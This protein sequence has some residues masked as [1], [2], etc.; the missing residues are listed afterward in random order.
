M[1]IHMKTLIKNGTII[2][3]RNEFQ[4]NLLIEGEKIAA[5]GSGLCDEKEVDRIID[6]GGKLVM[7]GG[8]DQHT[9]F[10]ALCNV[11]DK[12]TAGYE[13]T[14][15]AIVGGTT[16][17]VDFAPQD[18]GRGLLDSIDYRINVRAKDKACVDFSLHAM[19]TD[20]MDSIF[21]EINVF[22]EKGIS[23]IK[24]FMA[25]NGSPLHVDDGSYYRILEK[26]K[27]VGATV[28][29]HAEN[30]EILEF[31]RQ[32]C[33]KKGQLT[34]KYHYVSRPP[35]TEAEGVR[36]AAYL[37]GK[38]GTPLYVAHVTCIE[39]LK[40]IEEARGK[41]INVNG[42]TCTHYLTTTKEV[43]DNPNFNEAA[44]FVCSPALRDQKDV[45]ALWEALNKGLL[46]GISSD[47]CGID[48]AELKQAGRDDFTRIPN[49]AP[50]AG[51]RFSMI[52]TY[53]VETGRIS[54][55]KFVE[56][57][58]AKPA[59]INGIF[60]RKGALEVGSD[61]DIVI[62]DPYWEGVV[63]LADNP[64]GVD[65]NIYEGRQQTGKVET[66]LLRG[67]VAVEKGRFVGSYG[68]GKFIPAKMYAGCYAG[69]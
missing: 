43:L 26:A 17:I 64:N 46:T 62:F 59:K 19:V 20:L 25:Y 22:P 16:T 60:P 24:I 57:I 51:D 31:L 56:L 66:V 8:V 10:S 61:A 13:T 33:V 69:I 18:L 63:R 54:R 68:M 48:I 21:D 29:V 55:Q 11:G 52:W 58:A 6:A 27:D 34:P 47:H 32:E 3:D 35:F 49:G 37:A 5:I 15:S 28:F 38:V 42:E 45:E 12:D 2:T 44:K 50:G 40:E 36:R 30:G 1:W 67:N 65:Y 39:A 41:G 53:G 7:P 23:N 14:D 9:H 4:G